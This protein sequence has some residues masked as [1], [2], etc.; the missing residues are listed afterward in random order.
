M[1]R[2]RQGAHARL[3]RVRLR[4]DQQSTRTPNATKHVHT[5]LQRS[6][7][8]GPVRTTLVRSTYIVLDDT[9]NVVRGRAVFS[10]GLLVHAAGARSEL[11]RPCLVLQQLVQELG[12]CSGG[13]C[14]RAASASVGVR[15]DGAAYMLNQRT[16][17][18]LRTASFCKSDRR[19][20]RWISDSSTNEPSVVLQLAAS[21]ALSA[22]G[23]RSAPRAPARTLKLVDVA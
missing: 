13:L 23:L 2:V 5:H 3:H 1:G 6:A 22:S 8:H 19:A 15:A 7:H 11:Q 20:S 16:R 18:R 4:P 17:T 10:L 21:H 12:G 9:A 14:V